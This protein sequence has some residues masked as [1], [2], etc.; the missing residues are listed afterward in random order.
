MRRLIGA[1]LVLVGLYAAQA[2]G[3]ITP[4]AMLLDVVLVLVLLLGVRAVAR[5]VLGLVMI[6]RSL[7]G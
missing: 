6:A 2:N 3:L 7:A 1:V 4:G 5:L